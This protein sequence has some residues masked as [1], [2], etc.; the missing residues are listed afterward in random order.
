[1]PYSK[2]ELEEILQ[3]D[4]FVIWVL[5]PDVTSNHYWKNWLLQH[6]G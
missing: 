2:A 6:P 4:V 1:M 3:S 5:Q